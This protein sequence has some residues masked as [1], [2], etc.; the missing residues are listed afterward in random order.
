[1]REGSCNE[2]HKDSEE[3]REDKDGT[4]RILCSSCH[5]C[6]RMRKDV[7]HIVPNSSPRR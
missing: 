2:E 6:P 1:V 5:I 3:S 7:E 4:D